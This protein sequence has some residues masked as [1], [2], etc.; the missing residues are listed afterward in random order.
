MAI[1][2]VS[3][4]D[5]TSPESMRNALQRYKEERERIFPHLDLN[6]YVNTGPSSIIDLAVYLN[7]AIADSNK[8]AR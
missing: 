4:F 3:S 7:Q 5:L 2:R 8:A 6:I 1:A